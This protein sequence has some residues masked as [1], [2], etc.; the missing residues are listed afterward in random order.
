MRKVGFYCEVKG[1]IGLMEVL[2]L[3]GRIKE[4]EVFFD[5]M[6]FFCGVFKLRVYIVL[7]LVY[8]KKGL[9]EKVGEFV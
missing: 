3:F 1:F 4:V 9:F 2:G 7:F 8:V 5:E 6:K